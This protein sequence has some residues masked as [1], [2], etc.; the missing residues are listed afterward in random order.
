MQLCIKYLMPNLKLWLIV[1]FFQLSSAH[2]FIH[3][4][5]HLFTSLTAFLL[6]A[7]GTVPKLLF[8]VQKNTA[9]V[10]EAKLKD[11]CHEQG[12]TE[13]GKRPN[14]KRG[15]CYFSFPRR[16]RKMYKILKIVP[17]LFPGVWEHERDSNTPSR[18]LLRRAY[19]KIVVSCMTIIKILMMSLPLL[20]IT[21]VPQ[22]IVFLT[23]SLAAQVKTLFKVSG[24]NV[25][26]ISNWHL[27][28]LIRKD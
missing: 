19:V 3:S 17:A 22:I 15:I 8:F 24:K 12:Q 28:Y 21:S 11:L 26:G 1:F 9:I 14:K 13:S 5:S 10:T 27:C 23:G 4:W 20:W 7:I 2:H 18:S 25:G 6:L 16:L